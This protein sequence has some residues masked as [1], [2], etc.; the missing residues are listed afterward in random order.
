MRSRPLCLALRGPNSTP[1]IRPQST[2]YFQPSRRSSADLLAPCRLLCAIPHAI[3]SVF[4][5]LKTNGSTLRELWQ[6]IWD[7]GSIKGPVVRTHLWPTYEHGCC[8]LYTLY[9][10]HS[11]PDTAELL[12]KR[13]TQ[14]SRTKAVVAVC[15]VCIALCFHF[16]RAV[17]GCWLLPWL[18]YTMVANIHFCCAVLFSLFLLIFFYCL[19][20]LFFFTRK[21]YVALACITFPLVLIVAVA[22][23]SPAYLASFICYAYLCL[24]MCDS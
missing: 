19:F 4:G 16:C 24:V 14:N 10:R 11:P 15:P 7:V 12:V 23:A 6:H 20:L 22:V 8:L 13:S 21:E 18:L 17:A 3:A 2:Y 5:P 9:I 1:P